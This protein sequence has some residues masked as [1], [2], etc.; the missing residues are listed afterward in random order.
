MGR[1]LT[2]MNRG[3]ASARSIQLFQDQEE[4][5]EIIKEELS[6]Q[7]RKLPPRTEIIRMGVDILINQLNKE[8]GIDEK[9][10]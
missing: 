5:L 8:L 2:K 10:V 3:L 7:G 1:L 4:A 6:K 9:E